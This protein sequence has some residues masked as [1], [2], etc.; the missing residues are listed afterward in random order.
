MPELQKYKSLGIEIEFNS[1]EEIKD[2]VIEMV[3]RLEG[4]WKE[5]PEDISLQK[6]FFKLFEKNLILHNKR[7]FMGEFRIKQSSKFLKNN[8]W[9][10]Q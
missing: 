8:G 10:L 4:V 6:S 2:V 7:Q 1:P 5:N 3:E 9:W